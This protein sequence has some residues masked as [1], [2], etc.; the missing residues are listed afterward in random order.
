MLKITLQKSSRLDRL[1]E[2][3]SKGLAGL[4]ESGMNYGVLKIIAYPIMDAVIA[5]SLTASYLVNMGIRPTFRVTYKP[6]ESVDAPT[7]LLGFPA[8]NYRM[9]ELHEKL[10]AISYED[11]LGA[12]P[13]GAVYIESSG[14]ISA[15][16]ALILSTT[17]W[18]IREELKLRSLI[19]TYA[20]NYV[21]N[22]GKIHGL[23]SLLV[24]SLETAGLT[25]VT[26]VK[27][28]RPTRA[29]LC[30]ALASTLDPFY[31]DITGDKGFCIELLEG[32]NL[33]ELLEKK[34]ENL[35]PEDLGKLSKVLIEH[36]SRYARKDI[37]PAEYF[38]G[39]LVSTSMQ[40][41]D[42]R[43]SSH[44]ILSAVE[45]A[46]DPSVALAAFIDFETEYPVLEHR[47][48][49]LS[50]FFGE[51]I[52]RSKPRRVKGPNWLRMYQVNE[53]KSRSPTLTYRALRLLGI[54]ESDSVILV[55]RE[56]ELLASPFQ[57]EEALGYGSIKRLIEG[58]IAEQEGFM[59][60]MKLRGET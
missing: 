41:E 46:G 52:G 50:R 31:P 13:P 60:R 26:T 24:E 53:G 2:G 51:D 29:D 36:A 43:M 8:L 28:Y 33:G 18:G 39:I 19:G 35:K 58:K 12:P 22:I 6:P 32:N 17:S 54:V 57:V 20:S 55:E 59:L 38:G 10:V 21:D 23:D 11:R 42:P 14:S 27:V 37:D 49:H 45:A 16:I 1:L 56:G 44:A 5:A 40:P 9:A 7:L 3:A 34:P 4:L 25:M 30:E 47:L 48:E 15:T